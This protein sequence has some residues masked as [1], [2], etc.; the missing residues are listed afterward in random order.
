MV[1]ALY[2]FDGAAGAQ[3]FRLRVAGRFCVQNAMRPTICTGLRTSA[4]SK[5]FIDI[6]SLRTLDGSSVVVLK[7]IKLWQTLLGGAAPA[8]ILAI[9][10]VLAASG[11]EGGTIGWT[12][13]GGRPPGHLRRR[14]EMG[15]RPFRALVV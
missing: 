8:R 2:V 6:D 7:A 11:D 10:A 13:G 12:G 1:H 9:A 3:D 14:G 4:L 15:A 5:G